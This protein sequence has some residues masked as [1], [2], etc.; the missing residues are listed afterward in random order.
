MSL[1]ALAHT[2]LLIGV[3][4]MSCGRLVK[5]FAPCWLFSAIYVFVNMPMYV[6]ICPPCVVRLRVVQ[7]A[8][9]PV[10]LANINTHTTDT[11]MCIHTTRTHT[12]TQSQR[13]PRQ[14]QTR[15][16]TNYMPGIRH[17]ISQTSVWKTGMVGQVINVCVLVWVCYC[18]VYC[19]FV[20]VSV[21]T[22]VLVYS[23]QDTT[24]NE[25]DER[26]RI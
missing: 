15:L 23:I 5:S 2:R 24:V 8:A 6:F 25:S 7:S 11:H 10:V 16:H 19:V 22:N 4:W 14:N 21:F 9:R 3:M 17:N 26:R 12:H 18:C 20:K 1:L 13:W